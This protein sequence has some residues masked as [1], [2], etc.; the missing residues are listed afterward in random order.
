MGHPLCS[1][2]F[3]ASNE[4]FANA[5]HLIAGDQRC[6][7][8]REAPAVLRVGIARSDVAMLEGYPVD[9]DMGR[10]SPSFA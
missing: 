8:T 3:L 9:S 4:H 6:Q 7:S 10:V 5:V 1:T 2:A